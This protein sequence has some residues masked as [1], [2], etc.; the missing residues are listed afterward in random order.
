MVYL[1]SVSGKVGLW[2]YDGEIADLD[3]GNL[4]KE[5]AV[6]QIKTLRIG[7]TDYN[8][9]AFFH[10]MFSETFSPHIVGFY[11][12]DRITPQDVQTMMATNP[13]NKEHVPAAVANNWLNKQRRIIM[14]Y[15]ELG[16][17]NDL[18]ERRDV[19]YVLV[20]SFRVMAPADV[21]MQE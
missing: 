15:C 12:S 19:E 9:E 4:P 6:K 16:N 5:V 17:L 11:A 8:D 14:E 10:Q 2:R 21:R 18:L 7:G 1:N 13:R 20:K 3:Q